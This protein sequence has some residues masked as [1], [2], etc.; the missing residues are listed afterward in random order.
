MDMPATMNML[1]YSMHA[2]RDISLTEEKEAPWLYQIKK[3]KKKYALFGLKQCY[4]EDATY[5]RT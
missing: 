4:T 1:G 2:P 3:K 5:C